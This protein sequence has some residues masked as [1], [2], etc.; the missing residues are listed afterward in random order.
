LEQVAEFQLRKNLSYSKFTA[1][2]A[3]ITIIIIIIII[4]II[5]NFFLIK[6]FLDDNEG[7]KYRNM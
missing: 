7:Y 4:I 1:A 5:V 2:A 6:Y 3:I